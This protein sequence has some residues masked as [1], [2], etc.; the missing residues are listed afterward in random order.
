LKATKAQYSA[1]MPDVTAMEVD[2]EMSLSK[3]LKEAVQFP[4]LMAVDVPHEEQPALPSSVP[5]AYQ[6][7]ILREA[8][9]K[10]V[11]AV[12]PTGAGKTLIGA[13]LIKK[14][15]EKLALECQDKKVSTKYDCR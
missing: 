5:R 9:K 1:G 3:A 12:L 2:D 7:E 13:L 11:I 6:E 10:N 15:V 4:T 14:M 8:M